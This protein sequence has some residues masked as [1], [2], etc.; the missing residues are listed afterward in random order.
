V[1]SFLFAFGLFMTKSQAVR[2]SDVSG[3]WKGWFVMDGQLGP[4]DRFSPV[5]KLTLGSDRSFAWH[6][7][8]HVMMDL[9]EDGQGTYQVVDRS[10][11]LKGNKT[12][13]MDDG[14]KKETYNK[15]INETLSFRGGQLW[16]SMGNQM[17]VVFTRPGTKPTIP[18]AMK[19]VSQLKRSDPGALKLASSI[20]ARYTSLK[21]YADEGTVHSNGAGYQPKDARFLTRYLRPG[22]L[23]F[24]VELLGGGKV[25][26]RNVVWSDGAK[27][28]LYMS[29]PG[30]TE[31][32]P[33]LN[34][35]STISSS[36]GQETELVPELLVRDPKREHPLTS[37]KQVLL[38]PDAIWAGKKCRVIEF[39]N[40]PGYET[41]LWIDAG[42][43]LILRAHFTFANEDVVYHPRLNPPISAR[44]LV[45]NVP[46]AAA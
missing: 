35:L 33:V 28:W 9:V 41:T 45:P 8:N 25:Y 36:S 21:S 11:V 42:S 29:D 43:L 16:L 22:K 34:A 5:W 19:P 30:G 15:P 2:V 3:E 31:Q 46:K 27:S 37:Y 1:V 38:K 44:D 39:A 10:V 18:R 40:S 12:S 14:Y 4:Q 24:E 20:E 17:V 32:R 26:D 13:M 6:L 23:R 7:E